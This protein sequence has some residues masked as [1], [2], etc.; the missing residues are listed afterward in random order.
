MSDD[1]GWRRDP[2]GIHEWRYYSEGKP[3][4]HV[5]DGDLQSYDELPPDARLPPPQPRWPAP[6]PGTT[7]Y[8]P[9]RTS[10]PPPQWP[11]PTPPGWGAPP[12]FPDPVPET[13]SAWSCYAADLAVSAKAIARPRFYLW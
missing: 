6:V 4:G 9:P 11:Q 5:T 12:A 2:Y 8:P 10:Y 3:T 1:T 7:R 13:R